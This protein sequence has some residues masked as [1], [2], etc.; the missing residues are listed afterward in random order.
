MKKLINSMKPKCN[1]RAIK[2]EIL[3]AI[4]SNEAGYLGRLPYRLMITKYA[5]AIGNIAYVENENVILM[6]V[7]LLL[8]WLL[9]FVP[10]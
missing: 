3:C 8:L 10:L 9:S 1:N 5:T 7:K 4:E 2:T 6:S